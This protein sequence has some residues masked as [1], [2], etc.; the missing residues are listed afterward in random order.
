MFRS[1]KQ[2]HIMN[3][4]L[5]RYGKRKTWHLLGSILVLVS[6]PFLF[7]GCWTCDTEDDYSQFIWFMASMIA[8]AIGWPTVEINHLALIPELSSSQDERTGLTAMR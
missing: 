6:F 5:L 7:L 8:L 2:L 4:M 1:Y 3:F